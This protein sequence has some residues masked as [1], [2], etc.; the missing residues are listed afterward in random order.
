MA[1]PKGRRRTAGPARKR[2][3]LTLDPDTRAAISIAAIRYDLP[4]ATLAAMAVERGLPLVTEAL[5]KRA[6]REAGR[7]TGHGAGE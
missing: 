4:D 3:H 2:L 7:E 6:G 1:F 5:R